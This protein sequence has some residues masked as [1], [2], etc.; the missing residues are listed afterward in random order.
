LLRNGTSKGLFYH[1]KDPFNLPIG[2]TM[3]ELILSLFPGAGLLD[4]AFEEAGF[5]VVRGPDLLWGGDVK[6]FHPPAGH[7]AGI[8]GGPPCQAFSQ[9]R[10][11][12]IQRHGAGALAE[13]LIPQ[14]ERC[15]AEAAPTWFLMENVPAAPEPAIA[16]YAV[17][18]FI[19]NN[20][21]V[22]G[23]Q[24]RVRRFSF[25]VLGSEPVD[26]RRYIEIHALEMMEYSPAVLASG[27]KQSGVTIRLDREGR[28]RKK[29]GADYASRQT[30]AEAL[31][32][33]GLPENFFEGS[34]LTVEGQQKVIGNGVPRPMGRAVADAIC[35]AL[36]VLAKAA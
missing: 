27:N 12:V 3:A 33:Q 22:G 32:L 6:L 15:V 25:G 7:F 24:N 13:N 11:M 1:T 31:R 36:Q 19:L 14:Y 21:W 5:C 29:I 10:F 20:R 26:L 4:M 28:P 34:P 2:G 9:L 17:Q 16:G 35:K 8:I 23:E 30:V 18:S